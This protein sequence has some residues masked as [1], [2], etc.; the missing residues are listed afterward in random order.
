MVH[1]KEVREV[2]LKS[3]P[4]V[5]TLVLLSHKEPD[6]HISVNIEF[7]EGEVSLRNLQKRVQESKRSDV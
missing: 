3:G 1:I 7:G 6:S 5:E 2:F 4:N